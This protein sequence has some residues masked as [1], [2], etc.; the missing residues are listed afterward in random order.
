MHCSADLLTSHICLT[1]VVQGR[2]TTFTD[3]LGDADLAFSVV[4]RKCNGTPH[5]VLAISGPILECGPNGLLSAPNLGRAPPCLTRT[6]RELAVVATLL[7]LPG[8]RVW[9]PSTGW[10][11]LS[12][13]IPRVWWSGS[14]QQVRRFKAADDEYYVWRRCR[15]TL[16]W[17][18]CNERNYFVAS[19]Y[20]DTI[21]PDRFSEGTLSISPSFQ[22]IAPC[23][24]TSFLTVRH[25]ASR[26]SPSL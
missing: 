19:Y 9:L 18:L 21:S 11:A 12:D 23:I 4:P 13:W 2:H 16:E 26:R 24:I 3:R 5:E 20:N 22:H 10:K 1:E 15:T 8:K 17:T 25:L 14:G 7:D 6:A